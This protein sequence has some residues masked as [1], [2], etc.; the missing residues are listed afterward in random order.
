MTIVANSTEMC[1]CAPIPFE[2]FISRSFGFNSWMREQPLIHTSAQTR[3]RASVPPGGDKETLGMSFRLPPAPYSTPADTWVSG[4]NWC[5]IWSCQVGRQVTSESWTRR[6]GEGE[7][8]KNNTFCGLQ[9]Q[10]PNSFAN[11]CWILGQLANYI[12]ECCVLCCVKC[13]KW[14]CQEWQLCEKSS[15]EV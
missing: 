13:N 7:K 11:F 5:H 8:K 1:D 9:H 3:T 6:K 12:P 14:P 2:A 10:I 15:I 4:G